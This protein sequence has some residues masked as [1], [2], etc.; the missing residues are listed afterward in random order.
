MMDIDSRVSVLEAKVEHM[1]KDVDELRENHSVIMEK[2]GD[3]QVSLTRLMA[4]GMAALFAGEI[5][6]KLFVK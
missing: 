3:V 4:Y 1:R 6:L 2:L 5:I